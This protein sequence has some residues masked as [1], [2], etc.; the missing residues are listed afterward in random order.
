M[1]IG[2]ITTR[3]LGSFTTIKDYIT[4]GYSIGD[5]NIISDADASKIAQYVWK[6]ILE[7]SLQAKELMRI[8]ASSAAGKVSG[9]EGNRPIFLGVD[10]TQQ[11]I[12]AE[13]DKNGNR[14]GI[15]LD[16]S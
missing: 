2:T 9:M 10:G 7:N 8:I 1:S 16:G 3:G 15:T 5:T 11:R 4:R 13:T 6:E 12:T 14:T